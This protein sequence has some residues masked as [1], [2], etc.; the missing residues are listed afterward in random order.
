MQTSLCPGLRALVLTLAAV[1]LVAAG[2]AAPLSAQ[3]APRGQRPAGPVTAGYMTVEAAQVPVQ[4]TL[5]GRAV[6]QNA[7]Q[8]RPRVG[9]AVTAILYA[10]GTLVTAGTP[11]F[12]IDPLTY[13]VA[14][15]AAEA[16]VARAGA[17]LQAAEANFA[18]VERLQGSASSRAAFDDAEVALLKAR[19]TL[20]ESNANLELARAQLDWTTLRAPLTGIVGVPQVALGDLVTASQSAPLAEIVQTDPIHVDLSEPYPARLQLEAQAAQGLITLSEPQLQIVLDD[21]RRPEAAAR[22]VSTG[23]TVSATT[24]TR[25]LRFEVANPEGLI[26]PGMFVQ[27]NLVLG[28]QRAVLVPQRATQRERDGTLTAWIAE[29][30]KARKRQLTENGSY[31]NAWI[32]LAGLEPGDQLLLDGLSNLRDGQEVAPVAAEI[33]ETGVVRDAASGSHS[34]A[35]N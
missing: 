6:A 35:G 8:L 16:S 27:G 28:H 32:V 19:A 26:A 3:T 21:G 22:L 4:V 1:A 30:G 33:D 34:A 31:G 15:A 7:T 9:G 24:G 14:L 20:A 2:L 25:L 10:P 17:D 29:E 11:L 18:R 23:T 5:T 12:S 13:Q